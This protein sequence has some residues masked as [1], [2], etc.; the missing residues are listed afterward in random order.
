MDKKLKTTLLIVG[1]VLIL[2]IFITIIL[3]VTNRGK[4]P[5]GSSEGNPLTEEQVTL[6]YW[7][8]WE[9]PSVMQPVIKQF[10][11]LHPNIKIEYSQQSFTQYESI[12]H[13]RLEQ[14]LSTG[15]PTPDI[16]R[17]HSTWTPKYYN[18]LSPLPSQ[19]MSAQEYSETFYPTSLYDFSAKDGNIYAIP[20]SIDGLWFFTINSY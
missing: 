12:L 13:T 20:W 8:L 7:G 5:K 6:T 18:Y 19:I 2:L 11:D 17:I 14:S 1:G 9:P 16:F 3:L 15:E 10:E 4:Q